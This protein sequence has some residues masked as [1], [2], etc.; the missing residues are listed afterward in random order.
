MEKELSYEVEKTLKE[1]NRIV[2]KQGELFL[3]S[4]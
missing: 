4:I 2:E 3:F 1:F